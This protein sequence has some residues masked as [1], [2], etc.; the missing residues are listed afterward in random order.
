MPKSRERRR[1]EDNIISRWL[2][3][4]EDSQHGL[5]WSFLA[6]L[7]S[8]YGRGFL[9]GALEKFARLGFGLEPW[10]SLLMLFVHL[11]AFFMAL[12]LWIILALH[13][14]TG[15]RV[16]RI[17]RALAVGSPII[18]LPVLVD[19]L[20][21]GGGYQ[22]YYLSSLRQIPEFFLYTFIPW[23]H[24]QG[25]SPGIRIEVAL[26]CLAGA[27]YCWQKTRNWLK[28]ASGFLLVFLSCLW[29]GSWPIII[30]HLWSYLVG[31]PALAANCFGHGGLVPTD[32]AKYGLSF[33]LLLAILA[34]IYL[35]LMDGRLFRILLQSSRGWRIAH[36]SGMVVL[37]FVSGILAI[38]PAYPQLFSNPFDYL[39]LPAAVISI[40]AAF[41]SAVLINDIFDREADAYTGKPNPLTRQEMDGETA[42]KWAGLYAAIS[43]TWALVLGL[44]SLLIVLFI[45]ALSLVYSAPPLR[46]KRFY[47]LST[48]TIALASLGSAWLGFSAFGREHTLALFPG[49][50]AWFIITCFGLS[51][52][53]KDLND[54][55]GDRRTRVQTLP[56]LMG[57]AAG[58]KVISVL[59]MAGYLLGPFILRNYWLLVPAALAGVTT[60]WMI[61]R[62]RLNESLVFAVYFFYGA[63]VLLSLILRPELIRG[64]A[65]EI[66]GEVLSGLEYYQSKDYGR[67]VQLL[68]EPAERTGDPSLL[69]PLVRS[70][71]G[72]GDREGARRWAE[73]LLAQQP[74]PHNERA[75]HLLAKIYGEEGHFDKASA[76]LR[77]ALDLGLSPEEF[78]QYLGDLRYRWDSLDEAEKSY[79][80]ASLTKPGDDGLWARLSLVR[81]Q[82]ADTITALS[83]A[84]RALAINK[85]NLTASMI[86]ADV[87]LSR[88]DYQG[89]Q[90][91]LKPLAEKGGK[92]PKFLCLWARTLEGLNSWSQ[93]VSAYE[94]AVAIERRYLPA[95]LGLSRCYLAMGDME[96]SQKARE[97]AMAL[98]SQSL[99]TREKMVTDD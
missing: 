65:G 32:T 95:W 52:A 33:L 69:W 73:K 38:G 9:E 29:A 62:P 44:S 83:L 23:H 18:L 15:E 80:L 30:A 31:P 26:G 85:S 11:P 82:R 89:A 7:A 46:I 10:Q 88:E 61:N 47:P 68:E 67:A 90:G 84:D 96:L 59:V 21:F 27:W 71:Y 50:L 4:I 60:V 97:Q 78:H 74:H 14:V 37:G 77:Q 22:L 93:A 49:K 12:F 5:G 51:F 42:R 54:V 13:L 24:L 45:L 79:L 56:V 8:C 41:Q 28:A 81:L 6:M 94:R 19:A 76:I 35:R 1:P 53:T 66:Q 86:K 55:E 63:L 72:Q 92:N 91:I 40:I 70:L 58:R 98:E 43:L 75:Y 64:R 20:F 36:Y 3:S 57:Q 16:I 39:F 99:A 87:L 48:L 17:T 25:A 2:S 34:P